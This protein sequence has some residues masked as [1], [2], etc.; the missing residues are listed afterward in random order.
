M[1]YPPPPGPQGPPPQNPPGQNPGWQQPTYQ[2]QGGNWAAPPYGTPPP[3]N[4][5]GVII[6]L[7]VV[8]VAVILGIVGFVTYRLTS[9]GSDSGGTA[10]AAPPASTKTTTAP[11]KVPTKAAPSKPVPTKTT[12][13]KPVATE[14]ASG[15]KQA[16]FA[17]AGRFAAALNADD[18]A[19]AV[20]LTC[21][22]TQE[23]VPALISNWIKPPT[24]LT[25]TNAVVGQDPFVVPIS[26]TTNGQ[27]MGGMV[28]VQGSCVQVFNLERS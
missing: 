18:T 27:R 22:V 17:L 21:R 19:A 3:K 9:G 25:V 11:S 15:T 8:L 4:R 7:I 5:A 13:S 16:A 12:P 24:K 1:S 10:P 23:I 28:I 26:G 14:P 2:P 6:F 20:A